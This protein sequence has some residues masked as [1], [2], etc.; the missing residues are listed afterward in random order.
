[1]VDHAFCFLNYCGRMFALNIEQY[2][3]TDQLTG[4]F[5]PTVYHVKEIKGNIQQGTNKEININLNAGELVQANKTLY[6]YYHLKPNTII[7]LM[8]PL[9]IEGEPECYQIMK[10]E[11]ATYFMY[12]ILGELRYSY[13]LRMITTL[14]IDV[15]EFQRFIESGES[16]SGKY[17]FDDFSIA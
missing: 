15:L 11:N 9:G 4:E 2:A 17:R 16:Y 5:I 7:C 8:P 1:M 14:P 12:R 3:G 13:E 10:E 6:T